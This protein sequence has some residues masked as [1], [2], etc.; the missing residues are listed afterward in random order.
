M[1]LWLQHLLVVMLV[2]ACGAAVGRQLIATFR[3]KKGTK[4]GS[5]CAKGCQDEPSP[6]ADVK[7][8]VFIPSSS[9][10]VQK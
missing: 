3:M 7:R 5:C 10:R 8:V 4:L 2:A 9:L 1:D 6:A